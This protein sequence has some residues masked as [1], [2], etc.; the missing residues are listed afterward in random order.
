[1]LVPIAWLR[2]YVDL[3]ETTQAIVDQLANLGFPV[4]TVV[5]RPP[6]TLIVAGKIVKLE[7]HP[8]A[9]RLL[10][11]SIDTGTGTLL[12]IATAATNVA[13]SQIIPVA[14]IGSQ[15]ATL[16]IEPRKMR[17]ITSEGMLCSAQELG[18]PAEWFEDGIMQL[19]ESIPLGTDLIEH[20][21]L[22]DSVLD[23]EITSNRPDAM[24]M[25]GMARELAAAFGR[26]VRMPN[27]TPP[28]Y[29]GDSSDV[30]VTLESTDCRR[31]VAQRF[32]GLQVRPAPAYMRLRLAL[33]GQR[34]INNLV[35]IT[36]Y[37]MLEVCQ[38]LHSYD[39]NK[40][41]NHHIIVRDARFGDSMTTLDDIEYTLEGNALVNALLICD[42]NE[43][44]CLA[45]LKGSAASG[46]TE[47]TREIVIEAANFNGARVRR[48]SIAVALRTEASARHEKNLPLSLPDMGAA[49]AAVLLAAEGA[50]V[51]APQAVGQPV[52]P[53]ATVNLPYRDIPRYLGFDIS[54]ADAARYLSA[55]G[56]KMISHDASSFTVESPPWRSDIAINVDVIEELAR[57]AG[58]DKIELA[59]PAVFDQ[60]ISSEEFYLERD[61]AYALVSLGYRETINLSLESNDAQGRFLRSVGR[62]PRKPVE[63]KNPLS[64]EQ[65]YLRIGAVP[66][67]LRLIEKYQRDL[68]L[69]LFEITHLFGDGEIYE[70]VPVATWVYARA[71]AE[72]PEWRDSGFLEMRGEI[73][74]LVKRLTG[75]LP[76][77]TPD[78]RIVTHPG[79]SAAILVAGRQVGY[80]GAVD[81]R[82]LA[83]YD[84]DGVQVYNGA[85]FLAHLPDRK[86]PTYR[87]LPK[88]PGTS[89]DLALIVEPGRLSRDIEAV[90]ARSTQGLCE[91]ARVF[92]EYR[93]PQ[94]GE[95][96]KSVAVRVWLRKPD[97][98]ITDIEADAA[99]EQALKALASEL[100]AQ[101]RG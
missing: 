16:K 98:T 95:N 71:K 11:C 86:Q 61:I 97:A 99:I 33:A 94:V 59:V 14:L 70:E 20:F 46:V 58:Y 32:S 55:L 25:V 13:Q 36:N 57:M 34:P 37:V 30:T 83:T 60:N 62:L 7:K 100:G 75:R 29:S 31:Y 90:I 50:S 28:P 78:E 26:S 48:M 39:F 52:P 63:I 12:T 1:M 56:F 40:L 67:L 22:N 45:G 82:M 19:D 69:R 89:R 9:D 101:I 5:A 35:D 92:D 74:H 64:E 51:H 47:A 53:P 17:G 2:E 49:R 77:V 10:V 96:K 87:A 44:Q 72:E 76:E 38:P 85:L 43:P 91:R 27:F 66:S 18:F 54:H 24:C 6:L 84:M 4:E 79:K 68:P 65:R 8:N 41:A 42:E 3:P 21:H 23:V 80:I 81:P 93:G 15:L 88:F 73:D